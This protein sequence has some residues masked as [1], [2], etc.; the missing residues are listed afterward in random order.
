MCDLALAKK[1]GGFRR[2]YLEPF[3]TH[4]SRS[5]F[6]IMALISGKSRSEATLQT[7]LYSHEHPRLSPQEFL[8]PSR[9][10]MSSSSQRSDSATSTISFPHQTTQ[11]SH[12][13]PTEMSHVVDATS[14]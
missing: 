14:I 8:I 11:D 13:V 7:R 2:F 3:P 6:D 9:L 10:L 1:K 5:I 4:G 12:G